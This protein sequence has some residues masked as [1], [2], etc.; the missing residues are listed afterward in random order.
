MTCAAGTIITRILQ[1]RKTSSVFGHWTE[2]GSVQFCS[3]CW[4]GGREAGFCYQDLDDL[5]GTHTP[6]QGKEELL[7]GR[8]TH[9]F[10]AGDDFRRLT[11]LA[12]INIE[13][14]VI[15]FS[16]GPFDYQRESLLDFFFWQETEH[17]SSTGDI[18]N[19]VTFFSTV[20]FKIYL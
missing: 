6:L 5:Q 3:R 13:L 1:M 17:P 9:H 11:D 7:K 16:S 8:D 4:E 14:S 10:G 18:H 2:W 15:Q 12:W 20:F 19:W